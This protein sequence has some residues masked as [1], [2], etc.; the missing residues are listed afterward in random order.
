MAGATRCP[1]G[2][3]AGRWHIFHRR[4]RA[5]P[6]HPLWFHTPPATHREAREHWLPS[7]EPP[8]SRAHLDCCHRSQLCG[9]F[10]QGAARIYCVGGQ[11]TFP[12]R[13]ARSLGAPLVLP[14]L[15]HRDRGY[16]RNRVRFRGYPVHANR[17]HLQWTEC[18]MRSHPFLSGILTVLE[19][20]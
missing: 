10:Y 14:Q 19:E 2:S 12:R 6:Y 15:K 1:R 18:E 3:D 13:P 20:G 4:C 17:H 16:G 11:P 7:R 9:L 5:T 8:W